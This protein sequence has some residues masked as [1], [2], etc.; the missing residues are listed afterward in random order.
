MADRVTALV[1]LI[2]YLGSVSLGNALAPL[3]FDEYRIDVLK[4]EGFPAWCLA[5]RKF[6]LGLVW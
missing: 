5:L 6:I 4:S 3:F 2:C 1:Q